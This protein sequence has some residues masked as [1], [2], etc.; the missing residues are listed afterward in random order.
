MQQHTETVKSEFV[1]ARM[2]PDVKHAAEEVFNKLGLG[3][4]EAIRLFYQQVILNQGLPFGVKIPNAETIRAM[5][6][7]KSRKG[8]NSYTDEKQLFD[9]FR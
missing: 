3:H 2:S 7:V 8:L 6:Q 1:R 5:E 4:T 9:K